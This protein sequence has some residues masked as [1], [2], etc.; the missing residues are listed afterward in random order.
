MTDP[1]RSTLHPLPQCFV[2]CWCFYFFSS[3]W[4][5]LT[6][7][8]PER[9]TI[10]RRSYIESTA[11]SWGWGLLYENRSII[12]FYGELLFFISAPVKIW[13]LFCL[14]SLLL[15]PLSF[16][17][18]TE[19]FNGV[20]EL[21]EILGRYV[22]LVIL[23]H[24]VLV[25]LSFIVI[26]RFAKKGNKEWICFICRIKAVFLVWISCFGTCFWDYLD[27]FS[28]K[29]TRVTVE[30][31]NVK[32]KLCKNKIHTRK[33]RPAAFDLQ[34]QAFRVRDSAHLSAL[35][36]LTFGVNSLCRKMD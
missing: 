33:L 8:T 20:A 10:W 36:R 25:Q 32:T 21:L 6:A 15:S 12:F 5:C 13:S 14:T 35:H 29:K 9:G 28:L 19:H 31:F 7:K 4:S 3:S 17:Y 26:L 27:D 34:T 11:N 16:V 24:T 30:V 22:P 1:N 23:R 2:L 18:E